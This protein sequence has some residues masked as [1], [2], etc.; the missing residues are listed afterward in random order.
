MLSPGGTVTF[1]FPAPPVS[2]GAPPTRRLPVTVIS[3]SDQAATVTLQA[4]LTIQ[5]P[6]AFAIQLLPP[7]AHCHFGDDVVPEPEGGPTNTVTCPAGLGMVVGSYTFTTVPHP[8][9]Y[10]G[11]TALHLSPG[12]NLMSALVTPLFCSALYTYQA[13][14]TAYRPVQPAATNAVPNPTMSADAGYWCW[15]DPPPGTV[16]RLALSGVQTAT[17]PLTAGQFIL[18]GNPGN[19]PATVTGADVVYVYDAASGS[20][21]AVTTLQP[22]EGA[23]A[24]STSGGSITISDQ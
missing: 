17:I 18:V 1:T 2:P 22:G 16:S 12:W 7:Q 3:R 20:Y 24:Y 8:S 9:L 10:P 19:T 14:D 21:I 4:N 23:W 13:G 6:A 15:Y 11:T 5:V